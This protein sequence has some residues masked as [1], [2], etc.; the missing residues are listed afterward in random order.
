MLFNEK[1]SSHLPLKTQAKFDEKQDQKIVP[2]KFIREVCWLETFC[3]LH[4]F[5][6]YDVQHCR[7][8]FDEVFM[9]DVKQKRQ[10]NID[11]KKSKDF[12]YVGCCSLLRKK[13]DASSQ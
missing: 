6:K 8:N 11:K 4:L 5:V 12:E 13:L 1:E 2:G 3:G 7:C 9:L 10:A